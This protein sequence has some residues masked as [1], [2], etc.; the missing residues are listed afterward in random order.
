[1]TESDLQYI[2]DAQ[3]RRRGHC[4]Y[5][6]WR[7]IESEKETAYL[8]KSDAMKRRLMEAMQRKEDYSLEEVRA[9]VG[10]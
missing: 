10:L 7:E 8:L 2:S 9:R 1:M 3:K 4:A 6:H 5:R